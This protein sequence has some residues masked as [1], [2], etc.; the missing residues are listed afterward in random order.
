MALLD[1]FPGYHQI[2]FHK[3]DEEKISFIIPFSTYCY[4]RMPEGLKNAGPT[5]CR[6]TNVILKDQM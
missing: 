3:E 6:M 1:C 4:L 2:W 5:F